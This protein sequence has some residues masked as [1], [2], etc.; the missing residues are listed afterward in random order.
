MP[1]VQTWILATVSGNTDAISQIKPTEYYFIWRPW[2]ALNFTAFPHTFG[3]RRFISFHKICCHFV[4]L[5]RLVAV[6]IVL[7]KSIQVIQNKISRN[8]LLLYNQR[9]STTDSFYL[10]H[11]QHRFNVF[12]IEEQRSRKTWLCSPKYQD[13]NVRK[14]Q[15]KVAVSTS[16]FCLLQVTRS[17]CQLHY[18]SRLKDDIEILDSS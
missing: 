13:K 17:R 16:I 15:A 4:S 7:Y 12:H 2:F 6:I 8:L 1:R 10:S 14:N 5:S 9:Y 11:T 18:A 3:H